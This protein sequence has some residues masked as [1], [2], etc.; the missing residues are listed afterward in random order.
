[1]YI[2][3]YTVYRSVHAEGVRR[4]NTKRGRV[5]LVHA[6]AGARL[7]ALHSDRTLSPLTLLNSLS[8]FYTD[9]RPSLRAVSLIL[10]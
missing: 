9:L 8:S 10:G 2:Y 5:V 7:S 4:L 1:M 3:T 6:I